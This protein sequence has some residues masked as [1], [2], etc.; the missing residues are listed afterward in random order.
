MH[1]FVQQHNGHAHNLAVS[2][3]WD[4]SYASRLDSCSS[5]S[6]IK[7]DR[8]WSVGRKVAFTFSWKLN[9]ILDPKD[10]IIVDKGQHRKIWWMYISAV[11][12]GCSEGQQVSVGSASVSECHLAT[13]DHIPFGSFSVYQDSAGCGTYY[14]RLYSHAR[15]QIV[16][17]DE[18]N[19]A[20]NLSEPSALL[21]L[22]PDEGYEM[23]GGPVECGSD[24]N[25]S[26]PR[27]CSN[28]SGVPGYV[29]P[30]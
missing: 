16:A 7:L 25:A 20:C 14:A 30:F 11:G 1:G 26:Y 19:I 23:K 13:K 15:N 4:T 2:V 27:K 22:G 29:A 17:V 5:T 9:T 10:I 6:E 28:G 8:A 12:S 24:H 21:N 3:D 18:H